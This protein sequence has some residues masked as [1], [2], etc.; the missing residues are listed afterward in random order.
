MRTGKTPIALMVFSKLPDTFKTDSSQFKKLK[1]KKGTN[2]NYCVIIDEAHFLRNHQSQQSKS[3]YLLKDAQYKMVLTGTPVVNHHTDIFEEYFYVRK[4]EFKKGKNKFLIRQV[5]DFKNERKKQILQREVSQFSVNRRQ[6]DVLPCEYQP[7]EVLAKLKTLT[8]YPPALGFKQSLGVNETFLEPLSQILKT[9]K[10]STGLIIGQTNY[11][12]KEKYIQQFQNSELKI[13]LC[14]L[15][16]AGVGLNLSRAETIIFADR[17]YSPADNEQAEARFLPTS[18]E[19][20]PRTVNQYGDREISTSV[21]TNFFRENLSKYEPATLR[22]KRNALASYNLEKLKKANTKTDNQTNERNN[23]ILDFLFYTGL[24]VNELINLRH[25]DY[26]NEQLRIHGKGNKIRFV[27]LPDF[28]TKNF[29]PYSKNYLFLTRNGKQLTKGQIRRNIKRKARQAGILKNISPHSFR[30]SL[31][32]NLYNSGGKLET[33]QKQL[34]HASLDTTLG[35]IHNDYQTLY[36]DYIV[37]GIRKELTNP[38]FPYKNVG[39]SPNAT[40]LEKNKYDI[41]QKI[42]AY[43]Q[44]HKLTTEKVA[45]S[46]QLTTPETEDILFARIDKFTLD[47]LVSYATN[48]GIFLQVKE[49]N[50]NSRSISNNLR[51][52]SFS[53]KNSN[54]RSRK[55]L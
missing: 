11:Q 23:L 38:Y 35:Y 16:T 29:D 2:N 32:T 31:A 48:L 7:L 18:S 43:K 37:D 49:I 41:C 34:G 10:I 53:H 51:S 8:L 6:K 52:I 21:I 33:I 40:P 46:I 5:K 28:L 30:R 26:V 55:H 47:R 12:E 3:A 54:S 15:Q 39:L 25:S 14:N 13:L 36:A 42:L 44:D 45:K 9:Q 24:R 22:S 19:E 4:L 50:D 17:S 27:L 1:K 20:T